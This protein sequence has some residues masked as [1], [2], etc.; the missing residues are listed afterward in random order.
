[1]LDF[2]PISNFHLEVLPLLLSRI[3][4]AALTTI[5]F[6]FSIS[7]YLNVNLEVTDTDAIWIPVDEL[8]AGPSFSV[9]SEVAITVVGGFYCHPGFKTTKYLEGR[10]AG[11]KQ[12]GLLR[13]FNDQ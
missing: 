7:A 4:K 12:R 11:C 3:P 10:L 8:L 2:G 13:I 6:K 9:L 1:V 5:K